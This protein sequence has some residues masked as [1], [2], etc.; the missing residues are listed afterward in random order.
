MPSRERVIGGDRVPTIRRDARKGV[1]VR[2]RILPAGSAACR[3]SRRGEFRRDLVRGMMTR[4]SSS[5]RSAGVVSVKPA[6]R[7]TFLD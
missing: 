4:S 2:W 3:T 6:A 1:M 5:V 7:Y